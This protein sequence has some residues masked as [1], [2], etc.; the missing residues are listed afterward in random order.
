MKRKALLF[1]LLL[2]TFAHAELQAQ[3]V[4]QASTSVSIIPMPLSIKEAPGKFSITANT[5][6]YIDANNAE[7]RKMADDVAARLKSS[8]NK[9]IAVAVKTSSP[10]KDAIILTLKKCT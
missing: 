3:A 2:L 7:L 6:I 1:S 9:N 5:K 10:V 8:I 4:K